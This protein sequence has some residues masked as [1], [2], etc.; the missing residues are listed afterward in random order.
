METDSNSSSTGVTAAMESL[1][2][3]DALAASLIDDDGEGTSGDGFM[4][5]PSAA[6]SAQV[7]Q[8]RPLL[9]ISSR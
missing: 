5:K 4:K 9:N 6:L 8:I 7:K 3:A 2:T 1:T